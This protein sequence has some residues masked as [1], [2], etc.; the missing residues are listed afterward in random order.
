M[1][2]CFKLRLSMGLKPT[3]LPV[4]LG[5]SGRHASAIW[6]QWNQ[7]L[8]PF[9]GFHPAVEYAII[10]MS[11]KHEN[12]ST[13]GQLMEGTVQQVFVANGFSHYYQSGVLIKILLLMSFL[14]HEGQFSRF[15]TTGVLEIEG[16]VILPGSL[17]RQELI[18][19]KGLGHP[20]LL[21]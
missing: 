12:T 21:K 11:I 6:V 10:F 5:K 13:K 9:N 17:T 19:P 7:G 2:P 15:R 14:N 8:K 18:W 3:G 4:H 1:G 20:P 16:S